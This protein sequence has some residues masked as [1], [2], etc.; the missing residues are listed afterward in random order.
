MLWMH[1]GSFLVRKMVVLYPEYNIYVVDKLDYC[2]SLHNLKA[3]SEFPNYTFIKVRKKDKVNT[4]QCSYETMPVQHREISHHQ[5]SWHMFSK[6]RRS[7]SYFILQ[8]RRMSTIRLEIPLNLQSTVIGIKLDTS[9]VMTDTEY[10][11]GTMS[12]EPMSC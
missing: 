9:L 7:R 10:F 3:V 11:P 2:G 8:L 12:W 5:I 6:K 4:V 1:S